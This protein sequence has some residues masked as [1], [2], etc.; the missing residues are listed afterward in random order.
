[1]KYIFQF[2]VYNFAGESVI[3]ITGHGGLSNILSVDK[4]TVI[5]IFSIDEKY[6][7]GNLFSDGALSRIASKI[8]N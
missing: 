5:S 7:A 2:W 4:N 1:M 8:V 6:K 3:T